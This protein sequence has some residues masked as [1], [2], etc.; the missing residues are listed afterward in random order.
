MASLTNAGVGSLLCIVFF[1]FFL[2]FGSRFIGRWTPHHRPHRDARRRAS[3]AMDLM[4]RRVRFPVRCVFL[5][6][7]SSVY[8]RN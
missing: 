2:V 8:S 3:L 4:R 6:F 1:L 7:S 5:F